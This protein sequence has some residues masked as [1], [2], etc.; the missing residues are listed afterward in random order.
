MTVDE[1]AE[2]MLSELK[3]AKYLD[4]ETAAYKLVK[5]NKELIYHNAAGNLAIDKKVL[6]AF[7]KLLPEDVVWSLGQRHWRYRIKSDK[8]GRMQP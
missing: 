8:P 7:K 2:W 5:L 4:Q 3:R 1:A 6:A